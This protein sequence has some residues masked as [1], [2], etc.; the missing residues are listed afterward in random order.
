MK[1]AP[2]LAIIVPTSLVLF[3]NLRKKD[4]DKIQTE[5]IRD[6]E[7]RITDLMINQLKEIR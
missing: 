7:R 1:V 2:A 6:L 3:F 5:N 4:V